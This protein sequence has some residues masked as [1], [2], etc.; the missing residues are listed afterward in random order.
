MTSNDIFKESS[1]IF[2]SALVIG[3]G[4]SFTGQ[5][6][7]TFL[8][9][10]TTIL[11]IILI[12]VFAKKLFGYHLETN[13]TTKFWTWYHYGLKNK[14]HLN[15]PLAMIWMPLVTSL[16]TMGNFVWL[17]ITEFDVTARPERVAKRHGLYR[18]TEVTEWHMS[19]I[20]ATGIMANIFFGILAYFFGFEYF[21][22]L[23]I[24][25]AFWSIVPL[26]R[27]DGSKIFFGSRNLWFG[28]SIIL[29]A[30]LL[31]GL[32]IV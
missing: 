14:D 28:L 9:A 17:A 22:K 27:L 23:S 21:A 18:Y 10:F 6:F 19:L 3:L 31:W 1:V 4:L 7:S 11:M 13:V 20:A 8:I 15:A 25:Y 32:T 26:G 16:I 5:G 24:I 29:F 2:I 12:N 30:L